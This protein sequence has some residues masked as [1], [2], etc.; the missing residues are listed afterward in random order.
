MPEQD[1]ELFTGVVG[2]SGGTVIFPKRFAGNGVETPFGRPV[3]S[4]RQLPFA[5]FDVGRTRFTV[6]VGPVNEWEF[7]ACDC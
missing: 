7:I 6:P 4:P 5:F 2:S 1:C 3:Q